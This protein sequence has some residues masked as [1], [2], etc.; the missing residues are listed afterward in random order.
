M[1]VLFQNFYQFISYVNYMYVYTQM[2][3]CDWCNNKWIGQSRNK[4]LLKYTWEFG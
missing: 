4:I 3:K 1:I 2:Y